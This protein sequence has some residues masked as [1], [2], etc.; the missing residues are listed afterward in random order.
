MHFIDDR[1][2]LRLTEPLENVRWERHCQP[3][4]SRS[5]W[6][7][8]SMGRSEMIRSSVLRTLLSIMSRDALKEG[9]ITTKLSDGAPTLKH[10]GA[11]ALVCALRSAARGGALY[12]NRRSLQR[13]V[14]RH[15]GP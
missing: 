13:L 14:R 10:A 9:R 4:I 15:G 5:S 2:R 8:G 3:A 1:F 7:L 6:L 11:P 12:A